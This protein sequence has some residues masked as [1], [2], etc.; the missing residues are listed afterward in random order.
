MQKR[1]PHVLR[2]VAESPWAVLPSVMVTVRQI[3]AAH[4]AGVQIDEEDF[5]PQRDAYA[6]ARERADSMSGQGVAVL[7]LY[8][9][10]VPRAGSMFE[11]SGAT[12]TEAFG[13]M[14]DQ[15]L[16]DPEV[17]A[18]VVDV[19]SPG[20]M[21]AGVDE[22]ATKIRAARERKPI[23]AVANPLSAS[24]AYY[25]QAQATEAVVTP[26]GMVGSIGVFMA[27]EDLSKQQ[28]MLGVTT[29]LI[30]AGKYK[31]EAN[32][33]EP[34]SEEAKAELQHEVDVQYE[35]FLNA[36][37]A[38]RGVSVNKVRN[39][40]GE[41]RAL[42]AEDA[43]PARMV[44]RV[45]TLEQTVE[46]AFRKIR[47]SSRSRSRAAALGE[48]VVVFAE[49]NSADHALAAGGFWA[50]IAATWPS[51]GVTFTTNDPNT[52]LALGDRPDNPVTTTKEQTMD[53]EDVQ[54]EPG[55]A[56]ATVEPQPRASEPARDELLGAV[57]ELTL[58]V[59]AKNEGTGDQVNVERLQDEVMELR[60]QLDKVTPRSGFTP[61][62][63]MSEQRLPMSHDALMTAHMIPTAAG[64]AKVLGRSPD[65][66]AEFREKAD[67]LLILAAAMKASD[68]RDLKYYEQ[69]YLPALGAMDTQT[70]AEG[71]EFVPTILSGDTI[72]RVEL[73]LRVAALFRQ[74]DMPSNPYDMPGFALTRVRGGRH[75]EQTADSGQTGFKKITPGTRKVTLS[76]VKFAAEVLVSKEEEEDSLIPILDF[77][78]EEVVSQLA[79]DLED[80]T[81][82]GDTA[83]THMDADVT[84]ADDPRKV[85][86]GLRK[87]A[88]AGAKTDGGAVIATAAKMA[89][90]RKV[91]GKYGV[92]QGRI[93][94]IT[95]IAGYVNLLADTNLL[96][97]DKYGP[98]ATIH[99]GELAS[100]GGVPIVVSPF[101]RD[102]L[103][104]SGV[105]DSTTKTKTVVIT[106]NT[107]GFVY[108]NRRA[109]NVQILRELYAE[110]DQD[111]IAVNM[112]KAFAPLYPTATEFT[113]SLTYNL[114]N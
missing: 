1:L 72:R 85:W 79:N 103:N 90:N 80:A 105:Y 92:A 55:A 49:Q 56:T 70:T 10:I 2:T 57:R 29:T 42:L 22:L 78:R 93:V 43:L 71:K 34:L 96:T 38:G 86:D 111:A 46:R 84:A 40:Y 99:T 64:A 76:A 51:G 87:L 15:M 21:V 106:V 4:L 58:A 26:S 98:D 32:P 82:N 37:A 94:H 102:D 62:D 75:L 104:G 33:F 107:G 69:E 3:L 112:R 31:T 45:A 7:P 23:Y 27:H 110:Y 47:S 30:S 66:V 59:K 101:V 68:P 77:I 53:P 5:A 74:V 13:A 11:L 9:L 25:L 109:L 95:S 24:A 100:I 113:V 54:D 6:A 28:E 67:N 35:R 18:I 89:A 91:M 114:N 20:G 83:G 14:L 50:P 39:G 88:P 60:A 16:A 65:A 52:S 61:G 19:D 17:G 81:I 73:E 44:D 63:E 97:V 48:P 12:S 36:V 108:G 8:G 41:G